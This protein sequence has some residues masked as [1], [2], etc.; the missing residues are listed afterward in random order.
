MWSGKLRDFSAVAA[1]SSHPP[2]S[3]L[4]LIGNG[5]AGIHRNIAASQAR[6]HKTTAE[7]DFGAVQTDVGGIY[8][9]TKTPQWF[10][11]AIWLAARLFRCHWTDFTESQRNS[12]KTIQNLHLHQ[13][14]ISSLRS[15][16]AH[17]LTHRVTTGGRGVTELLKAGTEPLTFPLLLQIHRINTAES[18]AWTKM[19]KFKSAIIQFNTVFNKNITYGF[20]FFHICLVLRGSLLGIKERRGFLVKILEYRRPDHK[21][22]GGGFLVWEIVFFL[23]RIMKEGFLDGK[24]KIKGESYF[25]SNTKNIPS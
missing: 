4:T 21:Q 15:I 24:Q 2:P 3:Q 18:R 1:P 5:R 13:L 25:R 23:L 11:S 22:G 12:N 20:F 8:C 10:T 16:P 17:P 9:F 14:S 19:E 6:G 7:E